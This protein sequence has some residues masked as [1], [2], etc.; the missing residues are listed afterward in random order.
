VLH[1]IV[2]RFKKAFGFHDPPH[3]AVRDVNVLPVELLPDFLGAVNTVAIGLVHAHNLRFESLV[4][5]LSRTRGAREYGV[6]STG[7]ELQRWP[8]R[9]DSPS[10]PA[11]IDVANYRLV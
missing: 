7:G 3:R 1:H 10:M 6:V 2:E 8:D 4:V 5:A 11:G 9:L